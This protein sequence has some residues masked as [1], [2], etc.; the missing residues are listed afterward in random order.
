M[1]TESGK[2]ENKLPKRRGFTVKA[3][4]ASGIAFVALLAAV[5]AG[6]AIHRYRETPAERAQED[7]QSAAEKAERE[8]RVK[9]DQDSREAADLK[10]S[11][12][13][14]SE[15]YAQRRVQSALK[16]SDARFGRVWVEDQMTFKPDVPGIVCGEVN[17]RTSTGDTQMTNFIVIDGA[18]VDQDGSSSFVHSWTLHCTSKPA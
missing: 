18:V 4:M 14:F 2:S 15:A 6:R 9:A 7:R 16:D 8:R 10:E 13:S 3:I 11:W 17:T 1:T 5:T 12:V